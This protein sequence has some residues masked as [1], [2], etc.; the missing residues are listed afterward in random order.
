MSRGGA[1]TEG[2]RERIPNRLR[3]VSAE[4]G[5]GLDLMNHEITTQVEIRES[6]RS[7]G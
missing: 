2:E 1:E 7:A 4:P 6:G 3:A 5:L